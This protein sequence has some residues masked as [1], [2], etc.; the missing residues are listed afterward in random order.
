MGLKEGDAA[1]LEGPKGN[2]DV[3]MDLQEGV[4]DTGASDEDMSD[5]PREYRTDLRKA[6]R[7]LLF[8]YGGKTA[9]QKKHA[10]RIS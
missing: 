6:I 9:T 3:E 8:N 4:Q 7:R 10:E 2:D 5:A 1:E